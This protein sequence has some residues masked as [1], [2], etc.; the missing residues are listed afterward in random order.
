MVNLQDIDWGSLL[1]LI[2][3]LPLVWETGDMIKELCGRDRP[4]WMALYAAVGVIYLA[5]AVFY[6][7]RMY[8]DFSRDFH[9][10]FLIVYPSQILWLLLFLKTRAI[11]SIVIDSKNLNDI[12]ENILGD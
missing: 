9:G 10:S 2:L 3:S 1:N 11:K 5:R 6:F 7:G 8:L 12:R 4:R